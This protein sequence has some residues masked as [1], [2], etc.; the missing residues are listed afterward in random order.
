MLDVA[1]NLMEPLILP[2]PVLPKILSIGFT[3]RP[4]RDASFSPK[5]VASDALCESLDRPG[6]M[7]MTYLDSKS[8]GTYQL[9]R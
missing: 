2:L 7:R 4:F 5:L 9:G 8:A 3:V 6:E 1:S